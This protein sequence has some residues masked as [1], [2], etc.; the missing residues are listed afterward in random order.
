MVA[1]D[2]A[3]EVRLHDLTTGQRAGT[4]IRDGGGPGQVAV[5]VTGDRP[6]VIT[7]SGPEGTVRVWDPVTGR[8]TGAPLADDARAHALVASA[9][10]GHPVAVSGEWHDGH[11]R[12]RV[13]DLVIGRP[14]GPALMLPTW[15]AALATTPRGRLVVASGRDVTVL[16]PY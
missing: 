15:V 7:G 11:G 16:D 13:W 12:I 5:V 4:L 1:A 8:Q 10:E 14:A 2:D 9:V 6:L 3:G